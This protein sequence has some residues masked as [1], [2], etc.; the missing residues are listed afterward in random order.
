M[1]ILYLFKCSRV[2]VGSQTFALSASL[3]LRANELNVLVAYAKE[4]C[5]KARFL[6]KP[7]P[8]RLPRI[9]Y[10]TTNIFLKLKIENKNDLV[11]DAV[12]FTS[13]LTFKSKTSKTHT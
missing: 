11:I 3:D 10:P 8:R 13:K 6:G 1:I 7:N 9:N 5:L 4:C 12:Q 2:L